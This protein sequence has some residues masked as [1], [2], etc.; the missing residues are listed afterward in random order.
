MRTIYVVRVLEQKPRSLERRFRD[1]EFDTDEAAKA[2]QLV[3]EE[4]GT[5]WARLD[6]ISTPEARG[7]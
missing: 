5:Y 6:Y 4:D 2:F 1:V 3:A 7:R